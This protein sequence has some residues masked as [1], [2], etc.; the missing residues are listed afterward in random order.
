MH[1]L[2]HRRNTDLG[3]VIKKAINN[4]I[5]PLKHASAPSRPANQGN[6]ILDVSVITHQQIKAQF[7]QIGSV[8]S[9]HLPWLLAIKT[10]YDI[11]ETKLA[12]QE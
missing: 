8:G 3:I 11:E 9:D 7:K 10:E 5:C 12:I 1:A 6:A 2:N 4:G